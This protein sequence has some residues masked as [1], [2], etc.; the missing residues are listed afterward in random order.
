MQMAGGRSNREIEFDY[1]DQEEAYR[2]A[3][4]VQMSTEAEVARHAMRFPDLGKKFRSVPFFLPHVEAI[5]ES[6]LH[7]KHEGAGPKKILFVGREARRKG[8]DLLIQ[9]Y[10]RLPPA[11]R[12]NCKL[13]VVSSQLDGIM[14]PANAGIQWHGSLPRREVLRLMRAAHVFAMPSRFELFGFTFVEAMAAGCAVIGPDWEVQSEIL[15]FGRAGYVGLPNADAVLAA[16]GALCEN[17]GLRLG[18]ANSARQRYL[19]KY[20]PAAVAS[21]YY[22]MFASV[23]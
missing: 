11:T 18:L 5:E 19:E 3:G 1:V 14:V 22:K 10:L 23:A 13:D 4:A 12:S 8:L 15:D 17:T 2:I 21:E 16:L 20:A 6:E 9:A 7:A